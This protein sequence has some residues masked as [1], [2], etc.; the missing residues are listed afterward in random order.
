MKKFR[1]LLRKKRKQSEDFVVFQVRN[2]NNFA[3]DA[4]NASMYPNDEEITKLRE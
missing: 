1:S 4:V 2:V 3:T